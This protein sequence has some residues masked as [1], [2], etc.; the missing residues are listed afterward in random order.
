MTVKIVGLVKDYPGR[1]FIEIPVNLRDEAKLSSGDV[2]QGT[3]N[4]ILDPRGKDRK[5]RE[6]VAWEVGE[7]INVLIV[8]REVV[9]HHGITPGGLYEKGDSI[10]LTLRKVK[11]MDG[12]TLAI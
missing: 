9:E 6:K 2:I 5:I 8:P 7:F 12:T 11:K 10:Q 4:R 3:L 1:L